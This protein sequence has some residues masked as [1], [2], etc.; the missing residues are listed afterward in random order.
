MFISMELGS[1]NFFRVGEGM[2]QPGLEPKK[3]HVLRCTSW[4]DAIC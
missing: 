3:V 4:F 2:T 1:E